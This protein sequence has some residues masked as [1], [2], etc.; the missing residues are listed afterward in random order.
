MKTTLKRASLYAAAALKAGTESKHETTLRVSIYSS[1]AN[2]ASDAGI[3]ADAQLVRTKLLEQHA[4]SI[5]LITAAYAIRSL[6]AEVNLTSGV[7]KHL[8][9]VKALAAE[10]AR[11][12]ALLRDVASSRTNDTTADAV[13]LR[14]KAMRDQPKA[15]RFGYASRDDTVELTVVSDDDI[16]AWTIRLAR[17][18]EQRAEINDALTTANVTNF[19][20][21]DKV[22]IDTLR[23]ANIIV[24]AE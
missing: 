13:L 16:R 22:T 1:V 24:T 18:A 10:E 21:L 3:R 15:D 17:L 23:R 5:A 9:S 20:I 4:D 19:V 14:A 2:E 12:N 11:L 8:N 6:L 7:S